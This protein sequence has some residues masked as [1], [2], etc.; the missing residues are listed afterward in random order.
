MPS[1]LNDMMEPFFS[2]P[3]RRD[4]VRRFLLGNMKNQKAMFKS[5]IASDCKSVLD[6]G[7]GT[8]EF[9]VVVSPEAYHGVD[10]DALG[11]EQAKRLHQGYSFSAM[12]TAADIPGSYGMVALIDTTHHLSHD[13]LNE[14]FDEAIARLIAPG[15]KLLI[16]DAVHPKEQKKWIG[17]FIFAHD[18]GN[19]QRT[20]EEIMAE[21]LPK[22]DVEA[23]EVFQEKFLT[24]Y[25]LLAKPKA[26]KA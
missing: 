9:C 20:K 18:R 19:F 25:K 5:A 21:V 11:I 10:T 8:G 17:S 16:I 12:K 15:G 23:Y 3:N 2:S 14:T 7:C 22:F 1:M 6:L 4:I 24:F 26:T 13:I